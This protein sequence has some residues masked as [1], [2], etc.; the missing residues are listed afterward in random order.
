MPS[1]IRSTWFDDFNL[2]P[3]FYKFPNIW[4]AVTTKYGFLSTANGALAVESQVP[5]N[6]TATTT[7]GDKY[8]SLNLS[9][10]RLHSVYRAIE[11]VQPEAFRT[12][13]LVRA[14]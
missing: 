1:S 6:V 12:L 3:C 5:T 7:G 11:T 8:E 14:Y 2:F 9:A 4:G 10:Q 13:T